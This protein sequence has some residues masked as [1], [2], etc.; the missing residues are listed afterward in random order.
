MALD[1]RALLEGGAVEGLIEERGEI[2]AARGLVL[3]GNGVHAIS[4]R[5]R[6]ARMA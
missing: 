5:R 2:V 4:W 6:Q 1:D 3:G